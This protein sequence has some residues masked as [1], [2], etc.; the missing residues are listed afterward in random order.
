MEISQFG[1]HFAVETG[2]GHLMDDLADGLSGKDQIML[3]GG[4]P[5]HIPEVQACFREIWLDLARDQDAFARTIGDY[6]APQG[7]AA[8]IEALCEMFNREFQWDLGPENIALTN[9]SQTAFLALFNLFGGTFTEARHKRILFPLTPEYI[10][11]CDMGLE[12]DMFT[13]IRPRIE[14]E[15]EHLFKYHV[16]FE[17]LPLGDD[18]GAL[19]V[20]RPTN[21]S[22]NV[23][24]DGEIKQLEERALAQGIP[25]IIDNAYGAPFP[26]ILF[27]DVRPTWSKNQILCMSLSKLGLPAA[28]TGIVIADGPVIRLLARLNAVMSLAPGGLGAALATSLVT[29][30]RI[31]SLAKQVIRPY[32]QRKVEIAWQILSDQLSDLDFAIHSPEGAFFLWVWF[33][34]LKI[35]SMELYQRLK[36]RGVVIVPGEYFF[37]GL[38]E[39]W[40]HQQQ[41]IR[42]SIAASEA[43]VEKGLAIIADEVCKVSV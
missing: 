36:H 19:C 8:F 10:G 5:A 26:H 15:S 37:P 20:S 3:G 38:D 11:Y 42:I 14:I 13:A 25:L 31:L 40:A 7:K 27:T 1:Q 43:Q 29:D 41:C 33:R 16:D 4:N 39:P 24:T 35:S 17:N 6:D 2:I 34:G 28:R 21:P 32:Y 12:P 18:V 9:G 30:G 23:L 22:G